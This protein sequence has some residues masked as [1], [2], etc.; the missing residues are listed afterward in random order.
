ML[1]ARAST[2]AELFLANAASTPDAVAL[3]RPG[4]EAP[5]RVTYAELGRIVREIALG[6]VALGV[7]PGDRVALLAETCPEWTLLDGGI[8]CAGATVVPIYHTNSPEEC[9][10]VIEHSGAR[11]VVCED[12]TQLAKIQ[13][14]RAAC[15]ALRDVVLMD[16]A[17]PAG[18]IG[19]ADLRTRGGAADPAALGKRLMGTKPSDPATIVYTSGTTG[20]PKGCV[21]T[22]ANWLATVEMY[23]SALELPEQPVVFLFLPLAHSLARVTQLATLALGGTIAYWR[24]DPAKLLDDIAL[25]RPTHLPVVPRVLEKIR[26]RALDAADE[27]GAPQRALLS[28]SL[29]LGRRAA[30]HRH[31]HEPLRPPLRL[32]YGAADRLVLSRVRELFGDRI[33]QV[34]TGAA[35]IAPDVLR[36]FDAC[37]I[38]VYEGYGMTETCAAATLNVPRA[39]RIGS[40]GKALPGTGVRVA[41]DGEVLLHG[42]NVFAGYWRDEGATRATID[43]DGWLRTGDLGALD[44]DGFLRITGRKKDLII[45]S[46]GKNVTPSNIEAALREIRWVGQ[47]VVYGDRRPYLVAALTLDP[48]EVAALG[49]H[50]GLPGCDAAMLAADPR[51]HALLDEEV[52]QIN[53]GFARIEQVKRFAVLPRDFTQV[54]GE[55]TPTLK[56]RRAAVYEGY[57]GVFDALY[58]DAAAA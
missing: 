5:Q 27:G 35:P 58:E 3:E 28:G 51:V 4:G 45:T 39:L 32:A 44:A 9:R 33:Q 14:I 1:P 24:G 20:P 55:L 22:H 42:P 38:T 54:D 29:S 46:S 11:V 21:L 40:V 15:P 37:G 57:A 26:A 36:F 25:T 31:A 13:R 52:E 56:L 2:I 41:A 50:V 53:A 6:L 18:V 16:G 17:A 10:Y 47:A 12:A 34:L 48:D 43:A 23:A 8:A 7:E 49:E 19:L 30:A